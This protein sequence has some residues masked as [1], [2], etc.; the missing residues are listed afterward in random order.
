MIK[1]L[2]SILA[3][4]MSHDALG[5]HDVYNQVIVLAGDKHKYSSFEP[6]LAPYLAEKSVPLFYGMNV[7]PNQGDHY[8]DR[9]KVLDLMAQNF[10]K[11]QKI[12]VLGWSISAKLI[13]YLLEEYPNIDRVIMMDP[14]DGSPPL[15]RNSEKR[16]F[17]T[18][19]ELPRTDFKTLIIKA[20]NSH[21]SYSL[22]FPICDQPKQN[23]LLYMDQYEDTDLFVKV[24][25]QAGHLDLIYGPFGIGARI[26]CRSTKLPKAIAL[27]M[28][29]RTIEKF[30]NDQDIH[31]EFADCDMGLHGEKLADGSY[32]LDGEI[33]GE[34]FL[35]GVNN[36][37]G[38]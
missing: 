19:L 21:L 32:C 23:Y 16:P 25:K 33:K 36:L 1:I 31:S 6:H 30:M 15:S 38:Q 17:T 18:E 35:Q 34:E 10:D 26:A 12:L 13:V 11:E 27:W 5:K 14:M 37:D 3:M 20:E 4:A 24:I 7:N 28:V 22:L 2:I 29:K 9:Q 8:V